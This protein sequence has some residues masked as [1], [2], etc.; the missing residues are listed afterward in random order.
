MSILKILW[1]VFLKQFVFDKFLFFC[2]NK[3]E[4]QRKKEAFFYA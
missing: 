3:S 4:M 1:C 2:L